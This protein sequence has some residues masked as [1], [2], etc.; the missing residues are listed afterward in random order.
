MPPT[1][2]VHAQV[3]RYL[4]AVE[5]SGGIYTHRWGDAP[6]QTTALELLAPPTAVVRLPM[7]Y[8]HVSTMNRIHSD[9]RETDGWNDAE[10][11]RHPIVRA[12]RRTIPNDEE[13]PPSTGG[14]T[15]R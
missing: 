4:R 10:M 7:D 8:L 15:G 13:Q 6:I 3:Q 2:H 14:G 1:C 5:T 11:V 12:Y 9:G